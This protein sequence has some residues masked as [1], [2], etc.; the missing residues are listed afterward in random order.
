V[1]EVVLPQNAVRFFATPISAG[2]T[3]TFGGDGRMSSPVLPAQ[4]PNAQIIVEGPVNSSPRNK[5]E[6]NTSQS[7]RI[8]VVTPV[9][10]Q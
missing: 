6:I 9:D 10:W 4:T 5:I 7:G 1:Q 2:G 3:I 8:Q